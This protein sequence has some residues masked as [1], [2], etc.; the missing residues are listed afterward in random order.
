MVLIVLNRR[1]PS[2]IRKGHDK[3]ILIDDFPEGEDGDEFVYITPTRAFNDIFSLRC[4]SKDLL[5]YTKKSEAYEGEVYF[6]KDYDTNPYDIIYTIKLNNYTNKFVWCNIEQKFISPYN[7]VSGDY[8]SK[9]TNP[10]YKYIL[11][12]HIF[13]GFK[14]TIFFVKSGFLEFETKNEIPSW[15]VQIGSEWLNNLISYY[16]FSIEGVEKKPDS[17]D[18][19]MIKSKFYPPAQYQMINNEAYRKK[20]TEVSIKVLKKFVKNN[21][22]IFPGV[23][24]SLPPLEFLI[25]AMNQMIF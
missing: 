1:V 18:G 21:P 14:H 6:F 8:L 24:S 10:H 20:V 16:N 2:E 3:V 5:K 17:S 4:H 12:N 11:N 13:M 19:G 25:E 15:A 22:K 23:D 9:T 7:T